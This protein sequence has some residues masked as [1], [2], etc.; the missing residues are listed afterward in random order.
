MSFDNRSFVSNNF[1]DLVNPCNQEKIWCNDAK[2]AAKLH[3]KVL[4]NKYI[5]PELLN[6]SKLKDA[7]EM[8]TIA[9]L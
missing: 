2:A 1:L 5:P 7:T 6:C 3:L 4:K 8:D 9:L